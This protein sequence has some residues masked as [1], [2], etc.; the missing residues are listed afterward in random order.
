MQKSNS[1]AR[2]GLWFQRL[3]L[4]GLGTTAIAL[5]TSQSTLA[6]ERIK[7]NCDP[8][9]FSLSV[10][11]LELYAEEGEINNELNF[12]TKRLDNRTVKQLRRILRRRV[13][14][15]PIL[16]YRLTR[17]PMVAEILENLGKVATT[18][19]GHNGFY[20]IRASITN[21]AINNKHRLSYCRDE[22]GS[23]KQRTI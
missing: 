6:A 9:E 2:L 15:D 7:F 10:D 11:A 4:S 13:N 3:L 12:Y 8:L 22:F 17:S 20:T 23:E 19:H 14:I 18:H 1:L 16:L 5:C 21:T